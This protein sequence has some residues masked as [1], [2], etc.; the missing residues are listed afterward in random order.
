MPDHGKTE[1]TGQVRQRLYMRGLQHIL[2]PIL[3]THLSNIQSQSFINQNT[4]TALLPQPNRTK[5][6]VKT[7]I[8]L[9]SFN[10]YPNKLFQNQISK[11]IEQKRQQ[12]R[13]MNTF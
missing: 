8:V 7:K 9:H 10:R 13:Q 3:R 11:Q 6:V 2:T 5:P 12:Q 1:S 4:R